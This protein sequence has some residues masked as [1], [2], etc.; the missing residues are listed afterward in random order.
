[1]RGLGITLL[2]LATTTR[3]SAQDEA[4]VPIGVEEREWPSITDDPAT[5]DETCRRAASTSWARLGSTEGTVRCV[6]E[7]TTDR[8]LAIVVVHARYDVRAFVALRDGDRL[9]VLDV[10][11]D[12][13]TTPADDAE[14][15][16]ARLTRSRARG[17]EV[18]AVE[19]RT[20]T[21]RWTERAG[22]REERRHLTV[23]LRERALTEPIRCTLSVPLEI[24]ATVL[25]RDGET[26]RAIAST[27][28]EAS[29]TLRAD[30]TL[31]LR[32]R[33][34]SWSALYESERPESFPPDESERDVVLSFV[35]D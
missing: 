31:R 7:P 12:E 14:I 23:C 1:M 30:G 19:T 2:L 29:A 26:R 18:L 22:V 32:R 25:T 5:L 9:R 27:R 16:F 6:V 3:A 35:S 15:H 17:V 13:T 28:A 8:T 33:S 10:V 34:G 20:R 24:V 21:T 4:R 11:D